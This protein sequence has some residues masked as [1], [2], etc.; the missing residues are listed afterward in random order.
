MMKSISTVW[1]RLRHDDRGVT[2]PELLAAMLIMAVIIT[3]LSAALIGFMR[4]ND[5]TIMRLSESHDVKLVAA[6]FSEDVASIGVRDANFAL[7][8][9]VNNTTDFP[10]G[11][12]SSVL[13]L[14]WEGLH[15]T[16]GVPTTVRVRYVVVSGVVDGVTVQQLRRELCYGNATVAESMVLVRQLATPGPTAS[17]SNPT[18]PAGPCTLVLSIEHPKTERDTKMTITLTGQRKQT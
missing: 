1:K 5:D 11:T 3:P 9:S 17:C 13:L 6:Y 14:A 4:N 12:G 8:P 2:L 16:T 10:C 18:S 7:R 15:P